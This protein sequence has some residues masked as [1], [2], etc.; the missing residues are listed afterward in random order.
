M[1]YMIKM[2]EVWAA[3]VLDRPGMLA[4]ILEALTEA[5][6]QLEFLIARRVTEKTSR[7]FVA[8]LRGKKQR[9]AATEVGLVPAVRMHSLRIDGPDRRGLG[10]ELARAVAAAGINIRGASAA[11]IGRRS[12]FYLAFQAEDE[13]RA[14]ANA[15]RRLLRSRKR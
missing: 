14:A 2:V 10:A 3:D 6:A 4:R 7:V 11:T 5:G 1:P 12:V 8:P 9:Q 15:I 13:A